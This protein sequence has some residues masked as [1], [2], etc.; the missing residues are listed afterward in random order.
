MDAAEIERLRARMDW[1]ASRRSPPEGFPALPP[2]ATGRYTDA[3][4]LALE[5]AHLFA[6]QWLLA[7]HA[8]ELAKPGA[9]RLWDRAGEP[10]L[11]VRGRD[12]RIRAFYNACQH[13]GAPVVRES[14]GRSPKL[15]CKYHAWTYDLDGHLLAVPDE[16]DFTDLDKACLGLKPVR[17]ETWGGF[18]FVNLDG[19][20]PPLLETLAPV[21]PGMAQFGPDTLRF[22]DRHTIRLECNWKAAMDAFLEVY[23]LK[24]IH[25]N[26]V[27]QLL[28]HRR[29]TISLLPGGHSQM[30]SAKREDG[31]VSGFGVGVVPDIPTISDLPREANLSYMIFPNVITPTDTTGFPFLQF[32]P[33]DERTTEMEI[34]WYVA[35]WGEGE[36]PDF[37]KSFV[38]IF[39]LVLDEDTQNLSWIQRSMESPGFE[40]MRFNYQER[41]LY[42]FHECIDEAIGAERVPARCR[43]EPRL[44][45]Y[46]ER[47]DTP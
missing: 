6:R 1:E 5:R 38:G 2:V 8:D 47:P 34:S 9:Y 40:G 22:I 24:F 30:V 21:R 33:V 28:D 29:T 41:R 16:E 3:D 17:C 42:Y 25:P 37:W 11:I 4:F 36:M 46:V 7:A 19:G 14:S 45:R 10:I 35:D 20:A 39:D 44:S 23:H 32:W 15:V 13:R 26:T 43:V 27:N 31:A 18:V 12:D